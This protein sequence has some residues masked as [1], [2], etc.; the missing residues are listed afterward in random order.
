MRPMME[1]ARCSALV[2]LL[3]ATSAGCGSDGDGP[4][5]VAPDTPAVPSSATLQR[6][7][8]TTVTTGAHLDPDGYG[9]LNDEWDYDIG[10]GATVAAPIN[11]TTVLFLRPGN[12]VLSVVGVAGNCR[13]ENISDRAV[14]VPQGAPATFEFRLVCE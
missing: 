11:G 4:S 12:H 5:V 9:I 3:L 8:V 7:E 6:V 10:D 14:V 2:V 1:R 13:G